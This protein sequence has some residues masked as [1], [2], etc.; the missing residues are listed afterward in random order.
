[1]ELHEANVVVADLV[2]A[3]L[4]IVRAR[5]EAEKL[6]LSATVPSDLPML[7][8][9]PRAV[10][11]ILINLLSNAIKFTEPGG[12]AVISAALDNDMIRLSVTD[13]GIGIDEADL[14][15]ALANFGQ[16]DGSLDRKH[17]GTGLGLPLVAS[18][19]ELHGAVFKLDSEP[20]VGT[21][22]TVIFPSRRTLAG[23][24]SVAR[25]TA[26]KGTR[27]SQSVA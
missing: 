3:V 20:S 7:R 18:L 4:P 14:A 26:R 11:Q 19:V 23:P 16:V 9:D 21:C 8:A 1:M 2:N 12:T 27:P 25:T 24:A 22:A 15:I 13:T 17:E 10:K 5:A 6:T